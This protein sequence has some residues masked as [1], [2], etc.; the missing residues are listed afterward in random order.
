MSVILVGAGKMA[1]AYYEVLESRGSQVV[2]VGRGETTARSFEEKT[3]QRVERGGLQRWAA[4]DEA[5]SGD[6]II[7]VDVEHLEECTLAALAAG[8]KRV[9]VEKPGAMEVAGL[10]RI[11]AA[12]RG[13]GASVS[14]A[15]N[16]RFYGVVRRVREM[17]AEDGGAQIFHI[18]FGE[19]PQKLATSSRSPEVLAR[20]IYNHCSHVLDLGWFLSGEP[21][22]LTALQAGTLPWHESGIFAGAGR[23]NTGALFTYR[24]NWLVPGSW[25]IELQ[26]A[27]R[28]FVF[29]PLE[30]PI[31]KEN[32]AVEFQSVEAGSDSPF[33]AGVEAM[34]A[35][36]LDGKD[37]NSL[38]RLDEQIKRADFYN[39]IGGYNTT[40]S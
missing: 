12:A 17:I 35:A 15:Y 22:E 19:N 9:L 2:V 14:I 16:R 24:A 4:G 7:A 33:K 28:Q 27:R 26:T 1:L 6:F 38:C 8:A 20:T 13:A 34:L 3:S 11:S 23:T 31:W 21:V 40:N 37:A 29:A 18:E 5:P 32:S 10:H 25:R 39:R 30:R 36:F